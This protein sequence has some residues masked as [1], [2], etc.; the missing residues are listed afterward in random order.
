MMSANAGMHAAPAHLV[1]LFFAEEVRMNREVAQL[2][3]NHQHTCAFLVRTAVQG[4]I[5]SGP[6][7]GR[8]AQGLT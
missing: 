8:L 7:S 4:V 6:V 2:A 1:T 3:A 5:A